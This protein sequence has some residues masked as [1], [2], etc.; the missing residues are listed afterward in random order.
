MNGGLPFPV[1]SWALPLS[2]RV[3]AS[4]HLIWCL[5]I[6][7]VVPVVSH[8]RCYGGKGVVQAHPPVAAEWALHTMRSAEY[9][10]CPDVWLS[11]WTL[12]ALP[13]CLEVTSWRDL[14]C[15]QVQVSV[16]VPLLLQLWTEQADVWRP[17]Q[18]VT[19]LTC[20]LCLCLASHMSCKTLLTM[21]VLHIDECFV[22]QTTSKMASSNCSNC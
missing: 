16:D 4:H 22:M 5:L 6:L 15:T 14:L 3:A 21:L 18:P 1:A 9:V 19:R 7:A 13:H 11:C 20:L 17:L 8:I 2:P 10:C 12:T